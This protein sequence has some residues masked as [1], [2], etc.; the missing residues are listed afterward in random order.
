MFDFA[1]L[2]LGKVD[3]L[4]DVGAGV[5]AFLGPALEYYQPSKYLAIEMLP[6][7]ATYLSKRF[8]YAH[9]CHHAVGETSTYDVSIQRTVSP[10]SSSL[11]KINPE[12]QKWYDIMPHGFDQYVNE[13]V[14]VTTL[15]KLVSERWT[16][17]LMKM[18]VQG[19]EGRAI[20][21][22]KDTL[23]RTRALI[24]EV[25]FC[26]HYEGQSTEGEIYTLLT[27]LGFRFERWLSNDW[28]GTIHL[29][30]DALYVNTRF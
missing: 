23:R 20:R 12:S 10:D 3:T 5:G 25:L 17:D 28:N 13:S 6:E 4:V 2:E 8:G 15:D 18:D 19:Y 9:V 26:Q 7:R 21:G 27:D 22:G 1:S 16:V 30:G 11:L 29:Q 14:C 24:I